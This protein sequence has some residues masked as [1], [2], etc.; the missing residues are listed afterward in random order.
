M[1]TPIGGTRR[2]VIL[3]GKNDYVRQSKRRSHAGVEI[4]LPAPPQAGG[5]H[6]DDSPRGEVPGEIAPEALEEGDD[7]TE[8]RLGARVRA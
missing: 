7:D 5:Q 8:Q 6:D 4:E 2:S 3:P 1:Q